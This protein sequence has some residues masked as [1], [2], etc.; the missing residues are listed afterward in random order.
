M[1]L[2]Q[3]YNWLAGE[4]GPEILKAALTFLGVKEVAGND[5]N[6]LIIQW[7]KELGV[8]KVYT[9]DEV[10]WCGL[11]MGKVA[12][13]AGEAL[14]AQSFIW[15]LNWAKFGTKVTVPMLGDVLTFKRPGGGHVAL[16]VGEDPTCYHVIGGNQGD[17][18]TITRINKV[19]LYSA[20]RSLHGAGN[21]RRV[22]LSATGSVSTNEK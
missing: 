12:T 3:A 9:H 10:P 7:G 2:P 21:I 17:A 8:P 20:A 22:F 13:M 18:V 5:D 15:A 4:P 1:Q 16:Y 11:F 6:P 19:R 14:P